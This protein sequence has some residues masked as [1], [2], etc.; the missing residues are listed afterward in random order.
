LE[1]NLDNFFIDCLGALH[2]I[3]PRSFLLF[4]LRIDSVTLQ[5]RNI[6]IIDTCTIVQESY[7]AICLSEP[8]DK[9]EIKI[10]ILTIK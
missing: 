9:L 5:K 4:A 1:R 8:H 3:K 10:K 7:S 6:S 2:Y